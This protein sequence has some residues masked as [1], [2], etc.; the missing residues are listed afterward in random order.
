MSR[1][2]NRTLALT[3]VGAAAL[4]AGSALKMSRFVKQELARTRSTGVPMNWPDWPKVALMVPCK[5]VDPDLEDNLRMLLRQDY[6]LYEI[7][8]MT[9]DEHDASYPYLQRMVSEAEGRGIKAR[10]VFGGFSK[11]RC[12]KLDN[13]LAGVDALDADVEIFAWADSDVRV[14]REWLRQLVAPLAKDEVGATT[15]FRWYRPEPKRP[16]TYLLSLWTGYQFTHLH[17]NKQVHVWGGTMAVTRKFFDEMNMREIW[18]YALADDCTLSNEVKRAGKKVEFVM[19]SMT[20]ISSD[21]SIKDILIFAVRQGV[22]AKHTLKGVWY[23]SVFGLSILHLAVF[24][25]LALCLRAIQAGQ[26][27]PLVGLL[28]M[29]FV[30]GG[31]VQSLVFIQSIRQLV[32]VRE[33]NDP[34]KAQY[35]WALYS[36]FAY[37]FLWSTLMASAATD[38]FV[39]RGIFYRMLNE[40]ETEVYAY[41]AHLGSADMKEEAPSG[42][43]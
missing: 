23:P 2:L 31:I 19:P 18:E 10:I 7:I 32:S 36:P 27:L 22:I 8:F 21:H 4:L 11:Q 13:M 35:L 39:W 5:D 15:S 1:W 24:R 28:M 3:S 25:G 38:K 34:M 42:R 9:L 40:H 43:A 33:S 20:S 41:P 30:P 17:M 6:P 29:A 14:S 26:P 16:L 37:L 12:Q